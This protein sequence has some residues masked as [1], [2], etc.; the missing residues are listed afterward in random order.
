M[1][2]SISFVIL[3]WNSEKY[4]ESC[5]KSILDMDVFEKEIF[6][7]DNH[8]TD[9]TIAVLKRFERHGVNVILLNK[10][11]GTTYSRNIAIRRRN[12]GFDFL[13]ILDSDTEVNADAFIKMIRILRS[14][15]RFGLAGPA[16]KNKNG[17]I[18][19]TAK[20]FPTAKIKFYK[21]APF[22][23]FNKR[24]SELENYSFCGDK[25][26]YIV[27]HVIS[28]CWLIKNEVVEKVGLLD[29][30]I[31]YSPEDN[32]YC[33]RVWKAKYKVVFSPESLIIHDTQ[34]ISKHRFFS[35]VNLSHI[36][37]LIYYFC[38]HRY[39]L[40]AEDIVDKNF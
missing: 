40:D 13:C 31:F 14:D 28:A 29:E 17:D 15:D 23:S 25:A 24:G 39:W 37:G 18:Q 35:L 22:S 2:A 27:D 26:F 3:T 12:K 33:L 16:M 5:L 7:V 36:I 1:L 38:K 4:I 21:A 8:S 30:K 34:R 32:D 19:I 10:N 6:V 20:K 9:N 11:M